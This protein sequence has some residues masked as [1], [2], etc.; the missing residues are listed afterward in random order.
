MIYVLIT[1]CRM[2]GM[3]AGLRKDGARPGQLVQSAFTFELLRQHQASAACE[4]V[5]GD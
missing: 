2:F 5:E 3:Q 1:A 4:R